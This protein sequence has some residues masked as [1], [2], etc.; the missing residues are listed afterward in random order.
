MD[1]GAAPVASESDLY[2]A[3]A[4]SA[5]DVWAFGLRGERTPIALHWRGSAWKQVAVPAPKGT[6]EIYLIGAAVESATDIWVVGYRHGRKA[7]GY[8]TLIEHWNGKAWKIVPSP[9]P[10]PANSAFLY[11]VTA[12][13]PRNAWAVGSVG[14]PAQ[15]LILHWNGRVWKRVASPNPFDRGARHYDTLAGVAAISARNVWAVG[16][17]FHR[18]PSGRKSLGT[19]ALH[20][21]G[22]AWKRVPSP[23][24]GEPGGHEHELWDAA[25]DSAG[26]VWAVGDYRD[27]DGLPLTERWSAGAWTALPAPGASSRD[28]QLLSVSPLAADD[29]WAAGFSLDQD[30]VSQSLVLHWDG[31]AWSAVPLADP[32]ADDLL[33]GIAAVSPN[34][35]WAVGSALN[36][37]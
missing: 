18:G 5:E 7:R 36:D 8:R 26:E 19:L 25:T 32:G 35:V 34:D 30:S 11:G 14:S 31:D 29:V 24:P 10:S 12:L 4:V 27:G 3:V 28:L 13:S 21:D 22:K 9:N 20:W 15:T 1:P 37:S 2:E 6:T 23:N 17:Y 16:S 33:A